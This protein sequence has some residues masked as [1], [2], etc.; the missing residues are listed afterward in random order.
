MGREDRRNVNLRGNKKDRNPRRRKK[1]TN[2]TSG[3]KKTKKV[4]VSKD[5]VNAHG[6]ATTS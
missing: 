6:C 5:K 1:T 2:T 4:V 3:W